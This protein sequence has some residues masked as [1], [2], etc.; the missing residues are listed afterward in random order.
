[1]RKI[2]AFLV[3]TVLLFS[4]ISF[5]QV[6][7]NTD[8]TSPN[9][10]SILDVKSTTKGLL[11]PRVA[12]T[13]TSSSSPIV[14]PANGLLVYDTVTAGDVTPGYYFWNRDAASWV[15][16]SSGGAVGNTVAKTANATLLKTDGFVVASNNI[17]LTLPAVTSLDN[18]LQITVKNAGTYTDLI[19]VVGNGSATIDNLTLVAT[20]TRWKSLTFVAN[21]VNW[22]I[23]EKQYRQDNVFD[24]AAKGSFTTIAEAI[25]FLNLHMT[26]PST[27]RLGSGNYQV[28]VTQTINLPYP[29]TIEGTSFGEST[30]TVSGGNPA[31]SCMTECYFK[32][33]DFN[34]SG[35]LT[36]DALVFSGTFK[37]H[38]V[39]DC[40][41]TGFKRAIALTGAHT[42][43]WA[44]ETDFNDATTAGI[45]VAGGAVLKVSECDFTNCATGINLASGTNDTISI[46][47]C[48]FY[49]NTG[50][51][52]LAYNP[53]TFLNFASMFITNNAWDNVGTFI[54]GFDF[55]RSDGRDAKA[56]IENN[57]GLESEKPHCKINVLNNAST[58]TITVAGTWYK[59]VWTNTSSYTCKFTI[60]DNKITYQPVNKRD[61]YFIISGNLL[62]TGNPRT[63]S[64]GI[65][66]N[67]ITGTHYGETTLRITTQNNPFQWSTVVYIPDVSP[68]DYF[69]L[70][71][72]SNNTDVLTF[73]DINW[74]ADTQ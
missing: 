42:T 3:L 34:G 56:F 5:G 74:F 1:M 6:S 23:K 35:S 14:L 36:N 51:T 73:Q 22:L 13:G 65:V 7:I 52:G 31:F 43:V 63:I 4:L 15:R 50:Q 11:P 59:A 24:V 68:A 17:T 10:S 2:F 60:A 45:E 66:K 48:T 39:K 47:N 62:C 21:G 28:S 41:F 49:N 58:T 55:T 16:F 20:I 27:I 69:E 38:E 33:I 29:L 71:C 26:E 37:Y 64:L 72:T 32:M 46:L 54:S 61:M 70:W 30:I 67:G 53:A 9:S 12:L 25:A 19:T 40:N 18:G 8:G 44:F 57:A